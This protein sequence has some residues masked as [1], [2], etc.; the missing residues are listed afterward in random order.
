MESDFASFLPA[1]EVGHP[2]DLPLS[3]FILINHLNSARE[4]K[5]NITG[6]NVKRP[7]PELEGC[8]SPAFIGSFLRLLSAY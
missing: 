3:A 1:F 5:R 7:S 2:L 4:R 8:W 6:C